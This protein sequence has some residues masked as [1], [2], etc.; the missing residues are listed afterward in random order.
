MLHHTAHTLARRIQHVHSQYASDIAHIGI[1]Q[2]CCDLC[3]ILRRILSLVCGYGD[4]HQV[5]TAHIRNSNWHGDGSWRKAVLKAHVARVN[6][7]TLFPQ[8][9]AFLACVKA[10]LSTAAGHVLEAPDVF[11]AA[12]GL[13]NSRHRR[14]AGT[15]DALTRLGEQMHI[16][17][18]RTASHGH[19][20]HIVIA[21]VP[22]QQSIVQLVIGQVVNVVEVRADLEC[23]KQHCHAPRTRNDLGKNMLFRVELTD[24]CPV[25]R[26]DIEVL[27][28]VCSNVRVSITLKVRAVISA[29]R[30]V[31]NGSCRTRRI[32]HGHQL[33]TVVILRIDVVFAVNGNATRVW[34]ASGWQR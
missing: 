7:R 26:R 19:T 3:G 12:I 30:T 25:K 33:P 14:L 20:P 15:G 9:Q 5:G 10:H 27:S 13:R 24:L 18:D 4:A 8:A 21:V 1:G 32:H 17:A 16:H 2:S 22:D 34:Q 23:V 28:T 6:G 29:I 11:R 31:E